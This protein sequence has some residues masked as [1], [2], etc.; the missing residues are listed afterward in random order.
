MQNDFFCANDEA[1]TGQVYVLKICNLVSRT[2]FIRKGWL[3]PKEQNLKLSLK[4][5]VAGGHLATYLLLFH[6][7]SC[8]GETI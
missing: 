5:K 3:V 7:L 6:T 2:L 1:T 8:L 4:T